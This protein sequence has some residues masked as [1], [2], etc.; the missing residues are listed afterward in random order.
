MITGLDLV[1]EQINIAEGKPLSMKQ[2]DLR[3]NGHA[4]EV[5]VYAEDPKNNFMPDIG[6]LKV[7]KIP[8]GPGIRVDDGFEEGM[9]IPIYYDPMIAKLIV[10]AETREFAL[11][12]MIRAIDEYQIVGIQTTL[13]FCK[14]VMQHPAFISGAFD[15]NFVKEHFN[16]ELLSVQEEEEEILNGIVALAAWNYQNSSQIVKENA[17]ESG[18]V[19]SNWKKNRTT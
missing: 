4:L 18:S 8:Q 19:N 6:P 9:N 16:P 13:D 2:E 3:I 1:R 14:F 15:T 10:H 5:R 7:Y 12:R 11:A 17:D